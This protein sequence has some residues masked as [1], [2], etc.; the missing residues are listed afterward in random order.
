MSV[1]S[2]G[3]DKNYAAWSSERV[4]DFY[5]RER[6]RSDELYDSER[7]V[8]VPALERAASV[9]D[10]GCAAGGF[11]EVLQS[12]RPGIRYVG[13]DVA[14]EMIA[15]AR[16]RYPAVRFEVSEGSRLDFPD[17]SFD[18]V[19]CTGVLLHNPDYPGL[20]RELY[21]V[22]ASGC[23][24]DLPRLVTVPYTFDL[25]SSHMALQRR[26]AAG[27]AQG[28][29]TLGSVVPY[30]LAQAQPMFELLLEQLRPRPRAIAAVGYFGNPHDAAVLPVRP[31]CFCVVHLAKGDRAV[32]RTK[33]LLDLPEEIA[34][35][36]PLDGARRVPGGREMVRQFIQ[37]LES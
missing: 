3:E 12:L 31:V 19:L 26:F 11:S 21:R 18:L 23:V 28:P 37:E 29:G 27:P 16:R 8:L 6:H 35:Q 7:A 22:A 24:V 33:L 32:R 10:V 1:L 25:A 13:V 5:A 14:P 34:A 17:G 4:I 36:I 20:L 30:V 2:R 9:L 15:E